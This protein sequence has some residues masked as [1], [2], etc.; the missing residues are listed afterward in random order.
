MSE[1][2]GSL[3]D[4]LPSPYRHQDVAPAPRV[5]AAAVDPVTS[6]EAAER[7]EKSGKAKAHREIALAMVQRNPGKT[8]HELWRDATDEERKELG[9]HQELYKRL[10]DLKHDQKVQQGPKKVC[11]VKDA[12]MVTWE[13]VK[14]SE[15]RT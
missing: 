2:Q 4:A 15:A 10:N 6:H 13:L 3:F 5:Q 9:D 1:R 14:A 8:G 12:L 11:S 7:H